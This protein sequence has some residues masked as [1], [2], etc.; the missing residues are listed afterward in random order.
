MVT[1]GITGA[2]GFIGKNLMKVKRPDLKFISINLQDLMNGRA[3]L[4]KVDHLIHLAAKTFV[5]DSWKEP[6][7]FYKT[8][9]LGTQV[10]LDFCRE[11]KCSLTYVSSYV[12]G[13][14][15]Y[16]PVD[17]GHSTIANTPYNHSK[18]LAEELCVFYNKY[19]GLDIAILRPFNIYG[20]GQN[21]SFLIPSILEQIKRGDD[22]QVDTFEPKRDYLYI[23]DFTQ[24]LI[25][26]IGFTG[27]D[28]FNLGTGYSV[29][30]KELLDKICMLFPKRNF[31]VTSREI[32]RTNEVLDVVAQTNKFKNTFNWM[33]KFSL[34]AGLMVTI[35]NN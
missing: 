19:F 35:E 2:G 17:E 11:N 24:A 10:C 33:P 7:E 3:P 9:F 4:I 23:D 13:I 1:V 18:L 16:L 6:S 34:S 22:I 5:P 31:N 8:N 28:Y 15:S 20:P 12:Y 32:K 21:S 27:F 25:S 29:S 26:T 14:P 30:V